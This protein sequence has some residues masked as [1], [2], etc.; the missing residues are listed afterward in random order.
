M[1]DHRIDEGAERLRHAAGFGWQTWGRT[2]M[3]ERAGWHAAARAA[4]RYL[5]T[6]PT[7]AD[8]LGAGQADVLAGLIHDAVGV[9]PRAWDHGLCED[10]HRWVHAAH[11]A[12]RQWHTLRGA[13]VHAA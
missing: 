2:N 6:H 11:A 8:R 7:G 12:H 4:A 9:C 3:R 5:R 10:Q 13:H 1:T